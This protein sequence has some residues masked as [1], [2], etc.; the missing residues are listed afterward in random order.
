MWQNN[1]WMFSKI[2][3]QIHNLVFICV[4]V[5]FTGSCS[6]VLFVFNL[7]V[8]ILHYWEPKAL[9][10][11][12]LTAKINF[13]LPS[14]QTVRDRQDVVILYKMRTTRSIHPYHIWVNGVKRRPCGYA[15]V[16]FFFIFFISLFFCARVSQVWKEIF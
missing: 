2:L 3:G 5:C 4:C 15:S 1:N 10:A 14:C 9:I 11:T 13:S 8:M 6:V 16:W 7:C 12:V